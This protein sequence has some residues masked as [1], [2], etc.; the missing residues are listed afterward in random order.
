MR[1]YLVDGFVIGKH[2]LY[3]I[4]SSPSA[5]KQR[6]LYFMKELPDKGFTTEILRKGFGLFPIV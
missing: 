4:G 5:L 3:Y 1:S 2:K 6:S